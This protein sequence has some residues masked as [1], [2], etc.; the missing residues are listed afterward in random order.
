LLVLAADLV[1]DIELLYSERRDRPPGARP[2]AG[3]D[4]A[5]GDV[6]QPA[7]AAQP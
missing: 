7:L 2:A 3:V 6:Q 4:T 5:D 1:E